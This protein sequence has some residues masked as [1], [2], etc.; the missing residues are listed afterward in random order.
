[1]TGYPT[2]K[3]FPAGS[4]EPEPYEEAR[5]L[6][7][8]VH[9]VNTKTGTK[10]NPDG[11]LEATAGRLEALDAGKFFV[12]SHYTCQLKACPTLYIFFYLVS[13]VLVTPFM[14]SDQCGPARGE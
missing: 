13:I 3:F 5:E 2:L 4:L 1:M 10:R 11:S 12:C 7:S 8:L 9:F 6:E 14:H